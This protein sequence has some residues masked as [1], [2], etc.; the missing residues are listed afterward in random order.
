MTVNWI[1]STWDEIRESRSNLFS[2]QD[3][4][5]ALD[6]WTLGKGAESSQMW[7]SSGNVHPWQLFL[8]T[9]TL[10]HD[11]MGD[12][13]NY[14]YEDM[15]ALE[16]KYGLKPTS[17]VIWVSAMPEVGASYMIGQGLLDNSDEEVED[18]YGFSKS[19]LETTE[20]GQI[21]YPP[22]VDEV[23]QYQGTVMLETDDGDGGYLLSLNRDYTGQYGLKRIG[24]AAETEYKKKRQ[25]PTPEPG[26]E[27]GTDLKPS[28]RKPPMK[29][30]DSNVYS[31][32]KHRADKRGSHR[33]IRIGLDGTL[34]SFVPVGRGFGKSRLPKKIGEGISV[35]RTEDHPFDYW[36][37]EG[38]IPKDS[39]GAGL[40]RSRLMGLGASSNGNPTRN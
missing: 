13:D 31:V 16:S 21:Y 27:G 28:R 15:K 35:I 23:N 2:G 12:R 6:N 8:D 30:K 11:L 34:L 9:E 36:W 39:Y 37:F 1:T 14:P 7:Y 24:M 19:D 22:H 20:F 25:K 18:V 5:A 29:V 40:S 38:E 33:D 17:A 10:G 26:V 4:S 3:V 32:Q